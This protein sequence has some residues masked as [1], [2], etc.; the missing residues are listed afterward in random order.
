MLKSPLEREVGWSSSGP[1]LVW[2][3]SSDGLTSPIDNKP[4]VMIGGAQRA[5]L[6][7]TATRSSIE[8]LERYIIKRKTRFDH[9]VKDDTNRERLMT[10][11][12]S[13]VGY[14]PFG[15]LHVSL[16]F[17]FPCMPYNRCGSSKL[18]TYSAVCRQTNFRAERIRVAYQLS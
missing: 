10:K 8:N 3:R 1:E 2:D 15:L 13:I 9:R 14:I 16:I 7:R 5:I 18:C 4:V 12:G 6:S 11:G 17:L